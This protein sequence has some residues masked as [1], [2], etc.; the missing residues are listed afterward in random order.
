MDIEKKIINTKTEMD[1]NLCEIHTALKK[2]KKC[3]DSSEIQNTS[4]FHHYDS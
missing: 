1:K 3:I 4:E 2:L